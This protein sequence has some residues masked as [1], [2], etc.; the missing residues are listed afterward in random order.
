MKVWALSDGNPGHYNQTKAIAKALGAIE[1]LE[2]EWITVKLRL[3]GFRLLLKFILN[4]TN[5]A[6]PCWLLHVFYKFSGLPPQE[7]DCIVSTGGKTLYLNA[8]LTRIY[9]CQNFFSGSLRGLKAGYFTA[10]FTLVPVSGAE[11]N[12]V[13]EHAP[14]L[15]DPI[16]VA[17]LGRQFKAALGLE[18]KRLWAVLIGGNRFGYAYTDSDWHNLVD[19]MIRCSEYQGVQWL[20]TTSRRTGLEVEQKLKNLLPSHVLA[21]AV[22]WNEHPRRCMQEFLGAA[23]TVL[24]T[25]DS[26]AMIADSIA[27]EKP[28]CSISPSHPTPEQTYQRA[29]DVLVEKQRINRLTLSEFSQEFKIQD[30]LYFKEANKSASQKLVEELRSFMSNRGIC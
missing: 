7:P 14:T 9:H 18:E 8:C 26:M 4:H 20:L 29:L 22:W 2:L 27:S 23:E 28:V 12:V 3:G 30:L 11:N 5:V 21:D 25:E 13:L 15:I 24:V 10:F 17:Q 6:L 16:K 19:G 1:P